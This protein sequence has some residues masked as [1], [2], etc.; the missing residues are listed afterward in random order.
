MDYIAGYRDCV[1]ADLRHAGFERIGETMYQ[2][3]DRRIRWVRGREQIIGID[4]DGRTFILREPWD[5]EV[6]REAL[7]RR[8][9]VTL[10]LE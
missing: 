7:A 1:D 2:K 9:R 10:E 5:S 4:G 8:F 3:G 6:R